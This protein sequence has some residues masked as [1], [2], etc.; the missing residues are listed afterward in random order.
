MRYYIH[1]CTER[2]VDQVPCL[3]R[4]RYGREGACVREEGREGGVGDLG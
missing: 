4:S 3:D 1:T 2:C